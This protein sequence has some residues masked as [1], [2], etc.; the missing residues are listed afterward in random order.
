MDPLTIAAIGTVVG[1]LFKSKGEKKRAQAQEALQRQQYEDA[2]QQWLQQQQAIE[3]D[4][5][6]KVSL[7]YAFANAN[8]MD[9]AF[10]PE[11]KAMLLKPKP[12]ITPP[13]Y[14]SAGTPGFGWDQLGMLAEGGA[15]AYGSYKAGKL[16]PKSIMKKA[17]LGSY[18][19]AMPSFGLPALGSG[20][21]TAGAPYFGGP[22]TWGG[23]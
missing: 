15:A 17:R 23:S 4:R 14:R 10:T 20:F 16:D 19:S 5:Q 12:I 21:G 13:P 3:Q 22:M 6:Q 9:K 1:S 11:M 8:G 18:G 2:V 7:Y